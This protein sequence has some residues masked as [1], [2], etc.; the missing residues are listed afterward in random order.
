ML[1]DKQIW[2]R[3]RREN[4]QAARA[5]RQALTNPHGYWRYASDDYRV[6]EA[7][8]SWVARARRAHAIFMGREPIAKSF[9]CIH[10]DNVKGGQ[11]YAA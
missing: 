2:K 8:G 6:I 9:I 5:C 11:L 10:N 4:M 7:V 1:T 3:Q